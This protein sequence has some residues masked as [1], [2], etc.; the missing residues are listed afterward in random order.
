MISE[1]TQD[2]LQADIDHV[3][4]PFEVVGQ[5][6]GIVM[7]EARGVYLVDTEGKEYIDFSSQLVC[8]NLGHRR[9]EIIA[10]V[11]EAMGKIDYITCFYGITNPYTIE[12]GQKLAKLTPGDLNHFFFTSGG[13]ESL[14][15]AIKLARLYWSNK[16]LAGRYKIISLYASYHG[17]A[18]VSTYATGLGRG[19]IQNPFGPVSPG[20]IH[21]PPPYSY[22]S[23]FGDVADCGQTSI[24]FLEEVIGAEGPESIAAFMAEPILG[25]GGQIVP[26]PQWW[27]QVAEICKKYGIL[28]IV[29]EVMSG[30]A[31][32]GKM[33]ASEHWDIEGDIMT[34][35]KGITNAALPYG[36]VAIS[37]K[38]YEALRDRL[39]V[40]G[41]TYTGHPIPS[42]ASCA[43][44]D[45]YVRDKVV[46]NAA[47]VGDH[48][49]Q[50]LEAEFLPLPC[51]G[52]VGGLGVFQAIEL[53]KDKES[54]APIDP[55]VKGE[56]WGQLFENGVFT[57]ITGWLGNRMQ[58]CPPCTITV[59][60]ADK[61]L[62]IIY[63]LI[64]A[65]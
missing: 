35:A 65:L 63:P 4:H 10:A 3:I 51:V 41:F 1:R 14:D 16:G 21:V 2:L 64:A 48:I 11:V 24:D 56:L 52:D 27:P 26:P 31:R 13:S 32:T 49:K 58:I 37:N 59:E 36:A 53:V 61:A 45:I 17:Q 12:V 30:F 29:D 5:N 22:R 25:A 34:M 60:E 7:E 50:R 54:K 43:T 20:F 8:C 40:H 6:R 38:V 33:F 42:A 18:G 55:V 57:R 23:M 39:F 15:T 47:R 9:Q 46:E 19:A 44:L 62:D 28:L